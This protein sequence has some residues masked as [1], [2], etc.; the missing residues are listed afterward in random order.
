M[1]DDRPLQ[2]LLLSGVRV[3]DPMA[4]RDEVTDL[5]VAADGCLRAVPAELPPET[6]RIDCGRYVAAPGFWDLHVH[7]R[8]PGNPAAE[9][10]ASGTAAARAGGF[11]HVVTM[12][13]TA[14]ACDSPELLRRQLDPA[15][16]VR[17]HPAAAISAGRRGEEVTDLETLS[18]AGAAAFTDDGAMVADDGVMTAAMRRARALRRVIMDHAVVPALAGPG[19]IRDCALARRHGW[20]IFPPEAEVAAVVRDIRLCRETGCAVHIQHLSCAGA[21][22]AL[23]AAR[24]EGLPVSG[25]ATPHHLAIATGEIPGDDGHYRMNPPLGTREDVAALRQAVIDGTIACLATDH[26]PHTP[27]TKTRGF[28]G[29]APGVIGLETA[30]GVSHTVLVEQGGMPLMDWV[31]RWTVG[32]TAV[33]GVPSPALTLDTPADLVLLDLQTTWQVD[34]SAFLSRSR[35]TPF[36][37]WRLRGRAVMTLSPYLSASMANEVV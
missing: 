19:V 35:N 20:P 1:R 9:T 22:E 4:R 16:P 33:L 5:Y 11:T 24:R 3:V 29:A 12:P 37:G 7:F 32:P 23:R 13:N 25:E 28:A 27:E 36:G 30:V 18:R 34:P 8:D 6:R 15:L 21:I 2:P 14:P 17:I 10:L 26:A 31:A